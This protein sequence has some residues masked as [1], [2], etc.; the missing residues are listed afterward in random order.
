MGRRRLAD[1]IAQEILDRRATLLP[2]PFRVLDC[3]AGTGFP[4]LDLQDD[5]RLS[6]IRIRC[7]DVDT[8]ML[9]Q[10][11]QRA[12]ETH[13]LPRLN[14]L[15]PR[16]P[17]RRPEDTIDQL[18]LNWSDLDLLRGRYQYVMC[19]GNSLAYADTWGGGSKVASEGKLACL[20][21]KICDRVAPGGWLHIDAPIDL[22]LGDREYQQTMLDGEPCSIWEE[23][24][25]IGDARLWTV[26]F[27][28]PSGTR[29]FRRYSS[30]LTIDQLEHH[31]RTRLGFKETSLVRL[32]GERSSFGVIIAQRPM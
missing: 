29:Q 28:T 10:L 25:P 5:P 31:L 14:D 1:A 9:D 7:S 6:G 13:G 8:H 19:R 24:E 17:G 22:R 3:A 2:D 4:A 26:R 30:N 11:G 18:V 16:I 32:D 23:V 21:D 12:K 27:S 20:L 15:V